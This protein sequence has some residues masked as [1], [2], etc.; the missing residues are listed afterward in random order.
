MECRNLISWVEIGN[1]NTEIQQSLIH[2]V[3]ETNGLVANNFNWLWK[4]LSKVKIESKLFGLYI[5]VANVI[6]STYTYHGEV[7][8]EGWTFLDVNYLNIYNKKKKISFYIKIM[9]IKK[10]H[11]T[12]CCFLFYLLKLD[13]HYLTATVKLSPIL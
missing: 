3:N 9:L 5:S 7:S 1:N 11:K 13:Y 12:L 4:H 6:L 8:T 2:I 10:Q